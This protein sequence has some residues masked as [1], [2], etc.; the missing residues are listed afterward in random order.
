MIYLHRQRTTLN[1]IK[2]ITSY[3]LLTPPCNPHIFSTFFFFF[4]FD[5]HRLMNIVFEA[6]SNKNK[7]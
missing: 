1:S 5:N 3:I 7:N 2:T 6:L 4:F